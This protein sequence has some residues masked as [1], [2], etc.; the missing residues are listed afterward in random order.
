[1][2]EVRPTDRVYANGGV[3]DVSETGRYDASQPSEDRDATGV[4]P[5]E[6]FVLVDQAGRIVGATAPAC[7]L[8]AGD[9]RPLLGQSMDGFLTEAK[10]APW[11]MTEPDPPGGQ[12]RTVR[13]CGQGPGAD[14][15]IPIRFSRLEND[16]PGQ[17]VGVLHV[18]A[19]GSRSDPG[20][21]IRSRDMDRPLWAGRQVALFRG[22]LSDGAVLDAS[23]ACA[24]LLGYD[25]VRDLTGG[26]RLWSHFIDPNVAGR[27][28]AQLQGGEDVEGWPLQCIRRGGDVAWVR[29][30]SAVGLEPDRYDACLV[31]LTDE[32]LSVEALRS[33]R[34]F[35]TRL[36][37]SA[38][39][40]VLVLGQSG[41]VLRLNRYARDRMG[42]EESDVLGKDWIEMLVPMED[43]PA[44]RDLL[45]RTLA[46]EQVDGLAGRVQTSDG[47]LLMVR[48]YSSAVRDADGRVVG[49]L[50]VGHDITGIRED[51]QLRFTGAKM[52][53]MARLAGGVAHDF[54][55]Q[56]TVIRGYCDLLLHDLPE[57]SDQQHALEEIQQAAGRAARTISRLMVFSRRQALHPETV[58]LKQ[59]LE[60]MR[61][62]LD[63]L[64]GAQ[65]SLEMDLSDDPAWVAADTTHLERTVVDLVANAA[66]AM[67]HGGTV[68]LAT[69]RTHVDAQQAEQTADARE[70]TYVALAVSDT[71]RGIDASVR[72][73]LFE[74]FVTT[75][76]DAG[77]SGMGLATA[78]GF[79][80]ESGG[81]LAVDSEPGEGTTVTV[82]LPATSKA[83]LGRERQPAPPPAPPNGPAGTV[84]VAIACPSVREVVLHTLRNAGH[85]L[86]EASTPAEVVALARHYEDGI[87]VMVCNHALEG[88]PAQ[89][90]V[91]RV[92]QA[93]RRPAVLML[94]GRDG[95]GGNGDRPTAA[96][97]LCQPFTP[98]DL[99]GEVHRA[100]ASAPEDDPDGAEM[101]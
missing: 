63:Q 50:L 21:C 2:D 19:R 12:R 95:A 67:P 88:M 83:P 34:D 46:G 70:G 66:E 27:V 58:D 55:N 78:Y 62:P 84:L 36:V 33:E 61:Y 82:Y 16:G 91:Q 65:V 76:A 100:L 32:K 68:T 17:W 89:E 38:V 47:T 69:Y 93:G 43:R 53:A 26:N 51:Q 80:R 44:A 1:M 31:D 86:L 4:D 3:G 37:E 45:E 94:A 57:G 81:F 6:A 8:L 56:L 24:M 14:R 74:P 30:W 101:N 29:L 10:T 77:A 97:V 60:D 87:D 98:D 23:D 48:W 54:N 96:R 22:R 39:A 75:K 73:R 49:M 90:L 25:D 15:P 52:E 41:R 42:Y 28:M 11:S 5:D 9:D 85:V 7:Q 18:P 13:P 20:G 35:A 72:R 99:L 71:G 64:A 92:R 79:T 40:I 59:M